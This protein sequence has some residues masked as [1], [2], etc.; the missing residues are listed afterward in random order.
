MLPSGCAATLARAFALGIAGERV[1]GDLQSCVKR[2][3]VRGQMLMEAI[4]RTTRCRWWCI[5]VLLALCS[6]PG[7]AADWIYTVQRGDNPWSLTER[8]LAGVNYWPRIQ[9]LNQ[10]TDPEHIAPG[11]RLRIPV[12][13]LRRRSAVA[14]IGSLSG[15]ALVDGPSGRRDARA[16][17]EL[18]SGDVITTAEAGNLTL[19][20]GDGSR[21]LV[22]AAS[23]LHIDELGTFDNTDYYETRVRLEQGRMEN[24]VA[25]LG[26]GPGR[27]EI[28]TPAAVTAVRGTRFRVSADT[29][30][31]RAEVVEGGVDVGSAHGQVGIPAGFGTVAE[32]GAAPAPPI[33]LLDAPEVAALPT[34]L[35]R[36]PVAFTLPALSGAV[37]YRVQVGEV[38]G[39]EVPLLDLRADGTRLRLGDLADGRYVLRVRAIDANGLEGRDAE[40]AFVVDARPEPPLLTAPA[41]GTGVTTGQAEL[42]WGARDD[43]ARYRVQLARDAAF[44]DLLMDTDNVT[45]TTATTPQDLTPGNYYWRVAAIDAVEGQGPFSDPQ[46]FRRLP[47]A[48]PLE[49]PAVDETQLVVSWRAGQAGDRYRFQLAADDGFTAP[50]VDETLAEANATMPRPEGGTYYMRV[51]TIDAE[52]YAGAFG[53]PNRIEVPSPPSRPWWLLALLLPL[54]AL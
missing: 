36:L 4:F 20:F 49:E 6:A 13:W 14:R 29:T 35:D 23:E 7:H 34:L 12:D 3:F 51:Q 40:L 26:E 25:P 48:P 8:Y 38:P 50:L 17:L 24:L 28:E 32:T 19:V 5:A 44:D 10:I 46:A 39:F 16:G 37:G 2:I 18:H 30:K 15:S 21:V 54:L 45:A 11:T 43:I 47:P 27:F 42:Q 9:K 53:T 22:H 33:V 1:R 52:G 41:P 31:M